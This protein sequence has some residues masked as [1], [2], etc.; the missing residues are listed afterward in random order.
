[1]QECRVT[2]TCMLDLSYSLAENKLHSPTAL[3]RGWEQKKE[4][5]QE[6]EGGG[7][8]RLCCRKYMW[9]TAVWSHVDSTGLGQKA[10]SAIGNQDD[11]RR[12][13]VKICL[14]YDPGASSSLPHL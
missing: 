10:T 14:L 12:Q 2:G 13:L 7:R 6:H 3:A 4:K 5:A 8:E 11:L 1:M 9:R